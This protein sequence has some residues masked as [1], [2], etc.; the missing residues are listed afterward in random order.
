MNYLDIVEA[1]KIFEKGKNVTQFLRERFNVS[2]NTSEIIELAYELQ[3]GSYIKDALANRDE[4]ELYAKEIGKIIRKYSSN[5]DCLLDIGTGELTTLT[6]MLN[7]IDI[8]FSDVFAFDISWSRLK[9]GKEFFSKYKQKIDLNVKSFVA[10]IKAIPL[11]TKSIDIV[12]SSHALEP[13][14]KYLNLLIKELFRITKKKLILFE[15]SYELNSI[16]GKKRMDDFGYIR[17]IESS[18]N[19]LGGIVEKIIPIKNSFS[20]LNPTVCYV[21]KPPNYNTKTVKD[22]SSFTV[23]GTDYILQKSDPF[24]MSHDTGLIFPILENIPIL[25]THSGIFAAAKFE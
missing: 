14:A 20:L 11:Q 9:K 25:K 4:K 18:V 8:K 3:S 2:E 24:L 13:N 17:G 5:S 6:F 15:P 23:P 22:I 12:T 21:I 1:K 16:E 7:N 19:V 10:D